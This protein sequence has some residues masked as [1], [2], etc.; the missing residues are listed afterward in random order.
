M[1]DKADLHRIADALPDIAV[2]NAYR[3]IEQLGYTREQ[4]H[5]AIDALPEAAVEQAAR[6]L[7][8]F[9]S[10]MPGGFGFGVGSGGGGGAR[11]MIGRHG[12][13]RYHQHSQS[14]HEGELRTSSTFVFKERR[15]QCEE[16]WAV[17]P[18]GNSVTYSQQ[19]IAP[20]RQIEREVVIPLQPAPAAE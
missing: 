8:M 13:L 6:T 11:G 7:E 17:A 10:A 9:S 3:M 12:P 1:P 16:R 2:S 5:G 14:I 4:L 15:I 19:L 18:D 20:R